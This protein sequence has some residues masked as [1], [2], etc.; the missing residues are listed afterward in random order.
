L[1]ISTLSWGDCI[2]GN[3]VNGQGTY[4]YASGEKYVGEWKDSKK[5]GQGTYTWADGAEYVGEWEGNAYHGQGTLTFAN[6]EVKAGIWE[7]G[8]L[9]E[10]FEE[11]EQ[12]ER[13]YSACILDKSEGQDMS[14][15][16]VAHAVNSTC[17]EISEDPSWLDRLRYD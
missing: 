4:T 16:L 3:C 2:S 7:N 11:A 10:T 12:R 5:H 13:I 15:E 17:R 8:E 6:G 14:S 1:F 9:K